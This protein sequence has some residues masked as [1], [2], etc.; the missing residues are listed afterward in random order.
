MR[1]AYPRIFWINYNTLK[2]IFNTFAGSCGGTTCTGDK[3]C[4]VETSGTKS[5]K[6]SKQIVEPC[7]C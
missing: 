6:P 7:F 3:Y 2:K 1:L 5:C 4:H